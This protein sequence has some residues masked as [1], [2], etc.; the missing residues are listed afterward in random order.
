MNELG[1]KRQLISICSVLVD[2][3]SINQLINNYEIDYQNVLDYYNIKTNDFNCN[4]NEICLKINNCFDKQEVVLNNNNDNNNNNNKRRKR[5]RS[6]YTQKK[7]RNQRQSNHKIKEYSGPHVRGIRCENSALIKKTSNCAPNHLNIELIDHQIPNRVNNESIVQNKSIVG[8]EIFI[9][10][11]SS[12]FL[13]SHLIEKCAKCDNNCEFD[14]LSI[15]Y[16]LLISRYDNE[17]PFDLRPRNGLHFDENQT[18]DEDIDCITERET[19]VFNELKS[20]VRDIY[21]EMANEID[22]I[23]FDYNTNNLI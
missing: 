9:D 11:M 14:E 23:L 5:K 8:N 19:D 7:R 2:R 17:I 15:A 12:C 10:F 18:I 21:V 22:L 3:I 4:Q 20:C 13:K 16:N 6:L 1:D